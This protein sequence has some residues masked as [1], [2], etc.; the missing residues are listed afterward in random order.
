MVYG[1]NSV[2]DDS[3]D[4]M[5]IRYSPSIS[6]SATLGLEDVSMTINAGEFWWCA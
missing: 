2:F 6:Y 5:Q 4:I 1:I 3:T